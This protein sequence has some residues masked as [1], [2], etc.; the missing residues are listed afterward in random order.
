MGE[1][2]ILKKSK[3][4][5]EKGVSSLSD[6]FGLPDFSNNTQFFLIS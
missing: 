5:K 1:E 2:E 4:K 6:P 3:N